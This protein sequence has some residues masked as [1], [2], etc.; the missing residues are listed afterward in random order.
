MQ[1]CDFNFYNQ[2][3]LGDSI[4]DEK[5]FNK[6]AREASRVINQ[7]T[8]SRVRDL[9]E[10]ADTDTATSIK[11]CCCSLAEL[12]YSYNKT[13][14]KKSESCEGWSVTYSDSNRSI[15]HNQEINNVVDRYLG[16]TN[17]LCCWV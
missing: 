17:L 7:L 13:K 4:K 15:E 12:L 3:F 16:W 5:N 11:E 1:F 8:Y 6:V 9:S 14:L 2:T 10:I